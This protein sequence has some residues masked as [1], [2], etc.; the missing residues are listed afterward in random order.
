MKFKPGTYL[1]PKGAAAPHVPARHRGDAR[2]AVARC[3][4]AGVRRRPR[5]VDAAAR[6]RLRRQR[7]RAQDLQADGH[8][9]GVRVF[10]RAAAARAAARATSR[11][12]AASTTRRPTTSATAPATIRARRPPG[13]RACMPTT[14]RSPASRS[15]SRRRPTSSRPTCSARSTPVRSLELAV[16][17]ATQS[18][19][20]SGDC[21]YV[22]TVSWRNE[23]TP[24]LTEN[25][26]RV[27]FERL[28]GDGGSAAERLVRT[29]KTAS[30][31]D[32]VRAEAN[33][34]AASVGHSDRSK[35]GEYLG[36]RARDRAAH[37][38]GGN[39]SARRRGVTGAAARHSGFVRRLREAH[40]R[41][42]AARV[43]NR[44]DARVQHDSR[45]RGQQPA[46]PA[47]RRAGS[48]SCG[49][50]PP[51]RR[52][53]DRE[54]DQDRRLPRVAARLSCRED[55]HDVR[56]RRHRCSIRACSSTAAAWATATCISTRTC[57]ACC[58]A[59]SAAR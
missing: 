35:L 57:P 5:A 27:V 6:L 14:A 50:A 28:F 55:A 41:P 25:H 23:T 49:V 44:H 13:S 53:L 29:R 46:V 42:A 47:H 18:A 37:R 16:D 2:V 7:H 56:R 54:E 39:G 4:G 58:S 1:A 9:H 10:A 12:S 45:A 8:G 11:S 17:T 32:S 3:D 40:A 19:C 21:F 51:R 59:S 33:R 26:P 31:L 38:R 34:L 22:N 24:N 20:D 15:S 48:A 30:I 36:L 43:P 52:G